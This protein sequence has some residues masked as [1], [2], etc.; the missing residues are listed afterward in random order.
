MI[1]TAKIKGRIVEKEKSIQKIAPKAKCT[2]YTLGQK[3][4]NNKPMYIE[5]AAVLIEELDIQE[6]E[7]IE[8]FFTKIVA[9]RNNK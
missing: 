6:N 1:N 3:I 7:I 8:Y 4:A 5:E 2:P 9:K